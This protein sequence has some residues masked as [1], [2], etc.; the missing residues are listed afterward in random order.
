MTLCIFDALSLVAFLFTWC[1]VPE[2][3]EKSLEEINH[4]S[5]QANSRLLPLPLN[6]VSTM[7]LLRPTDLHSSISRPKMVNQGTIQV[8]TAACR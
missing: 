3:K 8:K 5:R 4:N 7:R 6:R 2:T 1:V